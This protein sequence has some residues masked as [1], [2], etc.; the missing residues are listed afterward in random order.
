MDWRRFEDTC[1]CSVV[2]A[3][4]AHH[5]QLVVNVGFVEST[6]HHFIHDCPDNR[7]LLNLLI[8]VLQNG[9]PVPVLFGSGVY[10]PYPHLG[11]F[12]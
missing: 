9:Q 8:F 1:F 12:I 5:H 10:S 7:H 3:V 11:H 2:R 6:V 4:L